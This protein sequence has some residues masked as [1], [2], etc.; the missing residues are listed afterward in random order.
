MPVI[1]HRLPTKAA[2]LLIAVTVCKLPVRIF[3]AWRGEGCI[4]VGVG[5]TTNKRMDPSEL[6]PDPGI[7]MF[8][9]EQGAGRILPSVPHL[10]TH[11]HTGGRSLPLP[12]CP[13]AGINNARL[14]NG[15]LAR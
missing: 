9:S 4:L 15:A 3:S 13:G 1:Q 11:H 7:W 14:S 8:A 5:H 10:Y 6:V 2:L 12:K